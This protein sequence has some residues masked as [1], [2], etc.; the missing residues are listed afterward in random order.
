MKNKYPYGEKM[1]RKG[2]TKAV[3]KVNFI[4]ERTLSTKSAILAYFI[5]C[6]S[7]FAGEDFNQRKSAKTPKR[8]TL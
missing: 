3:Y 1:A 8:Q 5:P 4:S 6:E 7:H 2:Q